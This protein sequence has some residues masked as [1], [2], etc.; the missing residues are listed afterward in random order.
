[1]KVLEEYTSKDLNLNMKYINLKE[2]QDIG[3]LVEF[4][5]SPYLPIINIPQHIKQYIE[6][7]DVSK[8]GLRIKAKNYVGIFPI[9]ENFI[10]TVNPKIPLEDFLY[11]LYKSKCSYIDLNEIVS[12]NKKGTKEYYPNIFEFL[13]HVFL[14]ELENIKNYGFLKKSQFQVQENIIKGKIL[15]KESLRNICLNNVSNITCGKYELSKENMYNELIKF[16]LWLILKLYA[17]F[18]S[19]ELRNNLF[20]KYKWFDDIPLVSRVDYIKDVE[21]DMFYNKIPGSRSYYYQILNYCLFFITNSSLEFKSGKSIQMKSFV[22]DMNQVFEKYI[23]NII[24]EN[25]KMNYTVNYQQQFY[26]FDNTHRY[27]IRPDFVITKKGFST[28]IADAKYKNEP[29]NADFYQILVYCDK[30]NVNNS[31]LICPSWE[32]TYS[33]ETY[34]FNNKQIYVFKFSFNKLKESEKNLIQLIENIL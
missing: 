9:N 32:D 20:E 16:T 6:I 23:Y 4:Q 5:D 17:N 34:I 29:S 22:V 19:N 33:Y 24:D 1:M 14:L 12:I 3:E 18:L 31:I 21:K 26:L 25:L 28:L 13:L 27:E 2:W 11:I 8:Y 7:A 30:F 10:L 15:V